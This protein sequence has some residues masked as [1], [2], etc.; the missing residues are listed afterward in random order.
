MN[1]CVILKHYSGKRVTSGSIYFPDDEIKAL[2]QVLA[3]ADDQGVGGAKG[4]QDPFHNV[5]MKIVSR[6][7]EINK[8]AKD[9]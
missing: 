8:A 5:Y 7:G 4:I 6:V 1:G 9:D 3:W 2:Y